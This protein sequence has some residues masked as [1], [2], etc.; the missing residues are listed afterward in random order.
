MSGKPAIVSGEGGLCP[1]K[2]VSRIQ[3][4]R[5]FGQEWSKIV[6]S[7]ARLSRTAAQTG[8]SGQNE[9]GCDD[10]GIGELP[11]VPGNKECGCGGSKPAADGEV[12]LQAAVGAFVQ[13]NQPALLEFRRANEEPVFG[14]V[15][16]L[17]LQGF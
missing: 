12:L 7:A 14:E 17:K 10:S 16:Q 6:K 9:K 11:S 3:R 1:W 4:K 5:R 8:R 13:R 2:S 15:R